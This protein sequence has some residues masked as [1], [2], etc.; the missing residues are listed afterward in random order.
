MKKDRFFVVR[1][2]DDEIKEDG[3]EFEVQILNN[4]NQTIDAVRFSNHNDIVKYND[5]VI[6]KAVLQSAMKQSVG[7]G[8]FVDAAGKSIPPF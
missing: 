7:Q 1:L 5:I 3:K 6:S 2:R 4:E 8:D